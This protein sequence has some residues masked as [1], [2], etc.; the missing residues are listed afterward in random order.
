M[1]AMAWT[2]E[3]LNEVVDDEQGNPAGA[4]TSKGVGPMT[5]AKDL[6]RKWMKQP[7]YRAEYDAL[8]REFQIARTLIKARQRAGL[9]QT[10]VAR[11]MRTSQSY[12]ARIESGKVTP[13]TAALQRFARATGSRLKI[14][15]EPFRA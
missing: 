5:K 3:T 2:V 9:T 14:V 8:E 6:H 10:D 12:V 15:F 1:A 11:R 4:A 13:S 7:A